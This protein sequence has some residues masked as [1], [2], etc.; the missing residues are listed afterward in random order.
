MQFIRRGKK[1]F[2]L[3]FTSV[4]ETAVKEIMKVTEKFERH[5]QGICNT[6][7][8]EQSNTRAER[9]NGIIQEV[10]TVGRGYKNLKTSGPP[11]FFLRRFESLPTT[12]MVEFPNHSRTPK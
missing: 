12:F 7:C 5:V 11:F 4:K 6:L 3:W 8:H 9:L 10:K 2:E 1:L